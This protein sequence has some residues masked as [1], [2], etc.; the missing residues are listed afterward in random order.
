MRAQR[1]SQLASQQQPE[2]GGQ[3]FAV[4]DPTRRAILDLLAN[5]GQ[6]RAGDIARRFPQISRPAVSKHLRILGEARLVERRRTGR[7]R[8]YRLN[9]AP[10]A[11][12]HNWVKRYESF[13]SD[14]LDALAKLV[15]DEEE[16][17]QV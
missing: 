10:L 2:A 13:W 9:A 3:F 11:E 7:E 15:E 6:M 1:R 12:V 5:R 16:E 4:A 8:H 17:P 14:R